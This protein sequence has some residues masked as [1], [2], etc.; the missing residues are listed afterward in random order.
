[1]TIK[2]RDYKI[3]S[4]PLSFFLKS[5]DFII[6]QFFLKFFLSNYHDTI[7]FNFQNFS[8]IYLIFNFI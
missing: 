3:I 4:I 7:F 6:L 2:K 5:L 1:M 8:L